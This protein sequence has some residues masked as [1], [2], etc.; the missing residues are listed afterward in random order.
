MTLGPAVV[1][2][3]SGQ[4]ARALISSLKKRQV[5]TLST[6]SS[7]HPGSLPL[8][9][10][11]PDSV[12]R[13]FLDTDTRYGQKP[14]EVFL[15]GAFTHV[16][17]CEE[18]RER[19]RRMNEE[20]PALVAEECARRG[21]KLTYFSTEYIF[22]AA[23]YEGGA[24][25]PFSETDSPAP[26]SFYGQCKLAAERAVLAALGEKNALILRTTMVFS[27]DPS[28]NN[29]LMQY[30]RQLEDV[31]AGKSPPIFR[32]P[33]D[34][35]STPTYAPALAE[36]TCALRSSGQGGIVNFVGADL[37]SRRELVERVIDAFGFSREQSL[38]GFRFLKTAELGQ[39]ARRPLTAGLTME[40]AAGLGLSALPLG[41]AFEDV[42]AQKR[43]R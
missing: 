2:G 38:G 33:E 34:Q 9:L 12:R 36:A 29:F 35:I 19:C 3:A 6:S 30:L 40:K 16:D 23:E 10:A 31:K 7:G 11:T 20:G 14:L 15:P 41:K 8:D 13:L 17:K 32:V 27:W 43:A 37:L 25:G 24:V 28:G 18:E 5:P 22:G 1:I 21:H 4:V 42:L 26:S 39:K